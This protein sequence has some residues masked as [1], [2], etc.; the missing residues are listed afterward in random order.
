MPVARAARYRVLLFAGWLLLLGA[1]AGGGGG[2]G[3]GG[4]RRAG[5]GA[6]PGPTAAAARQ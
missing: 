4:A 3:G 1:E 2:G 6:Q 5:R